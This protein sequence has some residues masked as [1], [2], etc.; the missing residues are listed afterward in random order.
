MKF[1][2]AALTILYT[3]FIATLTVALTIK[4]SLFTSADASS[5]MVVRTGH[6][7]RDWTAPNA[8]SMHSLNEDHHTRLYSCMQ[9]VGIKKV[10]DVEFRTTLDG[11]R[12]D[13]KAFHNCGLESD[14][15]WPR[16]LGFL[17]CLQRYF[18]LDYHQSNQFLQCLDLSEGFMVESI[19]PK[20][21]VYFMGSF[22][23]V[24]LLLASLAVI[25]SFL[26]FTAGGAWT[27]YEGKRTSEG[28]V[29]EPGINM[30]DYGHLGGYWLP[31][32]A[33]NTNA[34]LVW[35]IVMFFVALY[36]TYPMNNTWSDIPAEE[37]KHAFPS[38]PW[39]GYLCCLVF[40]AMT[41]FFFSY[42]LE[43]L[44]DNNKTE[45][46]AD[47]EQSKKLSFI[48]TAVPVNP[49]KPEFPAYNSNP[50][51]RAASARS[52]PRDIFQK[53]PTDPPSFSTYSA[54]NSPVPPPVITSSSSWKAAPSQ[55]PPPPAPSQLPPPP[56]PEWTMP[57]WASSP[58]SQPSTPALK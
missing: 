14:R 6:R 1:L 41:A 44:L 20:N 36:Y 56:Q 26:I 31:L 28:I 24:A 30:T 53:Q 33:F 7:T 38:T 51:F 49:V 39:G 13:A 19:Q 27:Y 32:S 35:S 2:Q 48:P 58:S 29:K 50:S 47:D 34:A 15:G 54:A 16:D 40:L 18:K 4:F 22:N 9:Q 11:F 57:I 46:K 3:I 5:S 12:Q 25:T 8:Y 17:R 55:L 42:Y 23:F 45:G 43:W 37:G 21:S 52:F 10:G